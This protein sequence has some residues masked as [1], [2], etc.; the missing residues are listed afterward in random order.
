[1]KYLSQ[2]I[3]VACMATVFAAVPQT[4]FGKKPS[5]AG[6]TSPD[7]AAASAKT[8]R[9][10]PFRGMISAV[11]AR[12]KTFTITGKGASRTFKITDKS[13]LTKAGAAATLKDVA[14]NEEVRGSYWKNAD[15]TLEA[16]TVKL[17][18]LTDA[19]KAARDAQRAK[20]A[21]KRAAAGS[22]AKS[23]PAAEASATP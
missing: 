12:A 14:A 18:P 19:E 23:S 4:A 9:A 3:A 5:P 16:R 15:G 7:A 2:L 17:G 10:V 13:V 6:A 21:A 11:D 22:P 1:M 8:E 20:R